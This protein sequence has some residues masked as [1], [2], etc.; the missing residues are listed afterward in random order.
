[1]KTFFGVDYHKR[2]SYGTIMGE[3]GEI[4]KQ[5]RFGNH[6]ES[7]ERFLASTA[8]KTATPCWKPRATGA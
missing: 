6:P 2:F 8:A 7:V 4:I 5:G 3:T 1:M